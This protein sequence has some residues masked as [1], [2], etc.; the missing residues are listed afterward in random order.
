FYKYQAMRMSTFGRPRII[1]CGAD[2]PQHIGVPRGCM[3]QLSE[4]LSTNGINVSIQDER[5]F[6]VP[7]NASFTGELRPLQQ[8]AA[9]EILKHDI[10][11]LSATTA[12]GKTVVAAY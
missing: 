1:S 12:F 3:S 2:F 10:G 4:M 5:I 6:G 7:V 9:V 11:V 8:E